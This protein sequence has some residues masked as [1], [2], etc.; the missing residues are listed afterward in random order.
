M[1][2]EEYIVP[3][4]VVLGV[5]I[6]GPSDNPEVTAA[7]VKEATE[8]KQDVHPADRIA[9]SMPLQCDATATH[10]GTPGQMPR[11]RCY[12]RRSSR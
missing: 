8:R 3:A 6:F 11:T 5:L 12:I 1:K 7:H 2:L 10:S 4:A 9:L